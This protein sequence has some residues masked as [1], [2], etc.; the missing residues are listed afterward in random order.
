RRN[1]MSDRPIALD[2]DAVAGAGVGPVV[3]HRLVRYAAVDPERDRVL[4]PA[5]AALE[6][7]VGHVLVE[8]VQDAGALVARDAV[9]IAGEPLVDVERPAPRDGVRAHHRVVGVGI[10]L[11]VLDTE[12]L[13]LAAI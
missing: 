9:D 3:T 1:R 4:A 13:V 7:R 8:I 11:L 12:I 5:E 6:Q 2:G 10:A